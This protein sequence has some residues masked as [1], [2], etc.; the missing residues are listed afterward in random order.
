MT[1]LPQHA[2]ALYEIPG[3]AILYAAHPPD[4]RHTPAAQ[5]AEAKAIAKRADTHVLLEHEGAVK[6]ILPDGGDAPSH[7]EPDDLR[8]M[9]ALAERLDIERR[10]F[11]QDTRKANKP[12]AKNLS[13][14]G[15]S[16]NAHEDARR[17]RE[18]M[19][20]LKEAEWEDTPAGQNIRGTLKRKLT[21]GETESVRYTLR[22]NAMPNFIVPAAD[23]HTTISLRRDHY[24][25][26]KPL[27]NGQG[28]SR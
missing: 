24:E 12:P 10:I 3:E 20:I 6:R 15:E 21:V 9:I 16:Q 13:G 17:R 2:K 25:A 4:E 11:P 8:R 14:N 1:E 23:R 28:L 7:V 27:I 19:R 22:A 5:L 26:L 18:G